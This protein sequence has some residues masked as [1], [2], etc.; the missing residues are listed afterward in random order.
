MKIFFYSIIFFFIAL[1][2][3]HFIQLK[4]R[5]YFKCNLDDNKGS[6]DCFKEKQQD[7]S[8]K[9]KEASKANNK[10][11]NI[12]TKFKKK[13]EKN[14]KQIKKHS[15]YLNKQKEVKVLV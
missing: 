14:E 15:E 2:I 8:V 6:H 10:F 13:N 3:I 9:L 7:N 12:I 4:E 1:I 5:E 11:K